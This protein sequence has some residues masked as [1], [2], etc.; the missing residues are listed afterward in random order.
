MKTKKEKK[1]NMLQWIFH[2]PF[3][4]CSLQGFCSMM[5]LW[6]WHAAH[7]RL[8]KLRCD[9]HWGEREKFSFFL[10]FFLKLRVKPSVKF[11]SLVGEWTQCSGDVISLNS[12]C[13]RESINLQRKKRQGKDKNHKT[14]VFGVPLPDV[15]LVTEEVTFSAQRLFVCQ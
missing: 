8:P 14:Q 6:I 13:S 5:C 9:F 10:S 15:H 7:W 1:G 4:N 2:W 11:R 3:D 12:F